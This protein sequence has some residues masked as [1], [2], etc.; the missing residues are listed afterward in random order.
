MAAVILHDERIVLVR[1]RAHGASYHLLPGGGVKVGES[2]GD[3]LA[4]EVLEETGLIA[5]A[6]R[7]LFISDA[8]APDGRRHMVQLTFLAEA[9]GGAIT[10]RPLDPRVE[11][12]ELADPADLSRYDLRPP[13]AEALRLATESGYAGEARYLG[14]LW[15]NGQAGSGPKGDPRTRG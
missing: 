3:A 14:A 12:V 2:V 4:R 10:D 7:P 6:V 13:M 15:T 9:T 8:I 1:H 5:H 11:G